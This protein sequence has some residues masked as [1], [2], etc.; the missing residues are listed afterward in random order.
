MKKDK[1]TEVMQ[2]LLDILVEYGDYVA[3]FSDENSLSMK[4]IALVSIAICCLK[5]HLNP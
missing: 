4:E 1:T 5:D 2:D 3:T